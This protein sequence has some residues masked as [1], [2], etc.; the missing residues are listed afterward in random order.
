MTIE[1]RR[2]FLKQCGITV[3]A[4][5]ASARAEGLSDY[6]GPA[7]APPLAMSPEEVFTVFVSEALF[8]VGQRVPGISVTRDSLTRAIFEAQGAA[9]ALVLAE[10]QKRTREKS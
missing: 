6:A 2:E 8:H 10:L 1:N 3:P 4:V 5:I 7:T 9:L